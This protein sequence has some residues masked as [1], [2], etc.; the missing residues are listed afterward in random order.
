[1]SEEQGRNQEFAAFSQRGAVKGKDNKRKPKVSSGSCCWREIKTTE[2]DQ[3]YVEFSDIPQ[4]LEV[5]EFTWAG[6]SAAEDALLVARFGTEI[7][8]LEDEWFWQINKING[9]GSSTFYSDYIYDAGMGCGI[10]A[11]F[12]DTNGQSSGRIQLPSYMQRDVDYP[13]DYAMYG[14]GIHGNGQCPDTYTPSSYTQGSWFQGRQDLSRIA[15]RLMTLSGGTLETGEPWLPDDPT[16]ALAFQKGTRI[17][18]SGMHTT[19]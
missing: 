4:D 17:I 19:T 14:I 10:L 16:G 2:E 18:A 12:G 9:D 1:M 5:L 13:V 11:G 3:T 7:E 15:F 6:W 8:D